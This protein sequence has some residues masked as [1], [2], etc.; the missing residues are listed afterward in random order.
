MPKVVS[1]RGKKQVGGI[2]SG[3][4][5]LNTTTVCCLK[6]YIFRPCQF[7]KENEMQ[8]CYQLEPHLV[9]WKR[10]LIRDMFRN[11]SDPE[12]IVEQRLA[13][14]ATASNLNGEPPF[15]DILATME[16]NE[17]QKRRRSG[18]HGTPSTRRVETVSIGIHFRQNLRQQWQ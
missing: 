11:F 7:L 17:L 5:G 15:L 6:D 16:R 18:T 2:A 12:D 8:L 14:T 10:Y 9:N 1:F 3:E 4:R 13:Y